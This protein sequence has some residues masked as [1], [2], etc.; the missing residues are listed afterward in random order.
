[1]SDNNKATV[2]YGYTN[3]SHEDFVGMTV[4]EVRRALSDELN[5]DPDASPLLNGVSVAVG[6][7]LKAGDVLTFT[8]TSGSKG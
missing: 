6:Y 8:K 4:A 5:I 3:L 1:M 7:K 2:R